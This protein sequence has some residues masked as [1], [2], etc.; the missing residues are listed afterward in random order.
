MHHLTSLNTV[1]F[2]SLHILSVHLAPCN[3]FILLSFCCLRGMWF[4]VQAILMETNRFASK[5]TRGSSRINNIMALM[6][7]Y[8]YEQIFSSSLI[9]KQDT[10]WAWV[11]FFKSIALGIRL[12]KTSQLYNFKTML[13]G[14]IF[15]TDV[16]AILVLSH[17]IITCSQS[18]IDS[19]P[20]AVKS[21]KKTHFSGVQSLS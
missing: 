1:S 9:C 15:S 10:L 7:D 5:L 2:H 18:I 11:F 8:I 20:Y 4:M 12:C 17:N 21:S 16:R 6:P 19:L 14:K 3:F 13:G